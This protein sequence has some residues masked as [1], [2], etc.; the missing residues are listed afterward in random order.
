[1]ILLLAFQVMWQDCLLVASHCHLIAELPCDLN[2]LLWQSLLARTK[3]R[4]LN[5]SDRWEPFVYRQTTAVDYF[6]VFNIEINKSG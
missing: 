2:Q 4:P 6:E 3:N 5:I 1:M